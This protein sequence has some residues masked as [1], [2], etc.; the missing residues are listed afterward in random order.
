[1]TT[2]ATHNPATLEIVAEAR[3]IRDAAEVEFRR[4]LIRA[5]ESGW[6]LR[7]I[8]PAARLHHTGVAHLIRVEREREPQEATR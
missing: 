6:S 8:A 2:T 5:H 1:M 3:E 4:A 7:Q